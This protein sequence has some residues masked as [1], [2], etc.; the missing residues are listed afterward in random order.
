MMNP[1]QSL[2]S[3]IPFQRPH[4]VLIRFPQFRHMRRFLELPGMLPCPLF[5]Q[6][7]VPDESHLGQPE[8]GHG[9]LMIEGACLLRVTFELLYRRISFAF[10]IHKCRLLG[11]GPSTSCHWAFSGAGAGI[12]VGVVAGA[13]AGAGPGAGAGIE[14]AAG[15]AAGA[16][17]GVDTAP[18]AGA[19]AGAG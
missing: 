5:E 14:A 9:A 15:A 12:G 6:V 10:L 3:G 19:G 18:G 13:G 7:G 11:A 16:G 4:A 8:V 17:A 2:I 1:R